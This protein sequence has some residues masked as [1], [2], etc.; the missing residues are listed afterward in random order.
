MNILLVDFAAS[1]LGRRRG[2][3]SWPEG[4][5][6]WNSWEVS[7]DADQ[8]PFGPIKAFIFVGFLLF[9]AQ[10]VAEIIKTGFV[11]MGAP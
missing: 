11:L 4:W 7:N 5:R 10:I 1:A 8:L 9:A 3:G 2:D 6:V